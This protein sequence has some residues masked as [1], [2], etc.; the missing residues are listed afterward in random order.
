SGAIGVMRGSPGHME[1]DVAVEREDQ[2]DRVCSDEI[3]DTHLEPEVAVGQGADGTD[4]DHVRGVLVVE[5]PAREEPDLRVVAALEDAEL[6][7]VRD[8]VAVP[9]ASRAEDAELGV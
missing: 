9:H 4:V 8:L 6:D 2:G 1:L 7:G 5:L 3:P